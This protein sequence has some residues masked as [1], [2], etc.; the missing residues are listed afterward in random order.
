MVFGMCGGKEKVPTPV[1]FEDVLEK[2]DENLMDALNTLKQGIRAGGYRSDT[3]ARA[4]D[5]NKIAQVAQSVEAALQHKKLTLAGAD[6]VEAALTSWIYSGG[7]G[8]DSTVVQET[9]DDMPGVHE[10]APY[11]TE[12]LEVSDS[13]GVEGLTEEESLSDEEIDDLIARITKAANQTESTES[14]P[15]SNVVPIRSKEVSPHAPKEG[16]DLDA[17]FKQGQDPHSLKGRKDAA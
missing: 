2:L 3:A 14:V 16:D 12:V 7:A 6:S 15:E 4:I 10:E 9:A 8:A 13:I 17:F 1:A 5:A 11:T